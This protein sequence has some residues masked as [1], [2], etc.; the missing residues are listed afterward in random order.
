[1]YKRSRKEGRTSHKARRTFRRDGVAKLPRMEVG[2]WVV[3]LITRRAGTEELAAGKIWSRPW[4]ILDARLQV[5]A[6]FWVR[7]AIKDRG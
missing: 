7:H 3:L 2:H 1:M 4:G 6:M 5:W